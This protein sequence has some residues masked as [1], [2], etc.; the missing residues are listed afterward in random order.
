LIQFTR[1]NMGQMVDSMCS[2]DV[3]DGREASVSEFRLFLSPK[4]AETDPIF[5]F[6][7]PPSE[8]VDD[9]KPRLSIKKA[10]SRPRKT[11]RGLPSGSVINIQQTD[12]SSIPSFEFYVVSCILAYTVLQKN[13]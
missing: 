11:F 5:Q 6:E 13:T 4:D 12:T 10:R 7:A 9:I 2:N 3:R 1:N 8:V